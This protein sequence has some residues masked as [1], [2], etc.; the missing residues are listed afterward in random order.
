MTWMLI[1]AG[2]CISALVVALLVAR[3]REIVRWNNGVC[4]DCYTNWEDNGGDIDGR[5]YICS[6]GQKHHVRIGFYGGA[7]PTPIPNRVLLTREIDRCINGR[8]SSEQLKL[9]LQ[10]RQTLN[11]KDGDYADLHMEIREGSIVF[12]RKRGPDFLKFEIAS[13]QCQATMLSLTGTEVRTYI[14]SAELVPLIFVPGGVA[15]AALLG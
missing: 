11:H 2:A 7:V 15:F 12:T 4:L 14:V 1:T 13:P 6:C 3:R 8:K 10:A 5:D 9:L